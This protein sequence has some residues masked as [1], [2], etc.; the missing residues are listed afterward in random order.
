MLLESSTT[1]RW[2]N[3]LGVYMPSAEYPQG[4]YIPYL[5]DVE[6]LI[7][8]LNTEGSLSIMGDLNAHLGCRS[9]EFAN[10]DEN[11]RGSMWN[12]HF[13]TQSSQCITRKPLLRSIIHILI[14]WKFLNNRF[15]YSKPRCSQRHPLMCYTRRSSTEHIWLPTS[16]LLSCFV[17]VWGMKCLPIFQLNH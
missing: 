11:Q 16:K 6:H 9:E 12:S 15:C 3:T 13:R 17:L 14:W 10:K 7:S 8:Q 2:L 5:K 4:I 1:E